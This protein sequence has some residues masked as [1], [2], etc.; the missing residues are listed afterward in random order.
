MTHHKKMSPLRKK[1]DL[2]FLKK[3]L[4]ELLKNA[5]LLGHIVDK[6]HRAIV[7]FPDQ[8]HDVCK[9]IRGTGIGDKK[10]D[11]NGLALIKKVLK[12]GVPESS[13]C[14]GGFKNIALPLTITGQQVFLLVGQYEIGRAHV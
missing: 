4:G 13:I 11:E 3:L 9:L 2:P 8:R 1:I 5:N 12:S 7:V 14:H 10:C 6:D